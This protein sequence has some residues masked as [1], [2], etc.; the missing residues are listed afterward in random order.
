MGKIYNGLDVHFE[1]HRFSDGAVVWEHDVTGD[2]NTIIGVYYGSYQDE[3]YS[4]MNKILRQGL[5][6]GLVEMSEDIKYR[7]IQC[8]K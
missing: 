8:W 1:M 5:H 6:G 7:R 3:P 2:W 4:G